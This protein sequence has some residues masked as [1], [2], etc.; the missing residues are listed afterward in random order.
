MKIWSHEIYSISKELIVSVE[1]DDQRLAYRCLIVKIPGDFKYISYIR[2]M[3]SEKLTTSEKKR[4][5]TLVTEYL[6]KVEL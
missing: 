3:H 5:K 2:K 6:N 4:I 1:H